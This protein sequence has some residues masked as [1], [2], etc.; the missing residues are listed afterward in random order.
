[1]KQL[2]SIIIVA[3]LAGP[4]VGPAVAADA[5]WTLGFKGGLALSDLGGDDVIDSELGN[6]TGFAGGVFAQV[7]VSQNFGIRLEGLYHMK[8]ASEDSANASAT[9]KFDYIE[10]PVLLVGQ[11]PASESATLS[12]FAGPVMAFNTSSKLAASIGDFGGSVDI[13]DYIAAFEFS[14]AFGLGAS[15]DVGSVS[16]EVDGRYQLGLTTVDDGLGQAL[17]I[18]AGDLDIKNQGWVFMAGVGFPV[19]D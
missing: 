5:Q 17:D 9:F 2:L 3:L 16:I 4:L 7:D 14:L 10:F 13:K 11:V 18:S 15:F 12:A 6:R 8:G 19:G 1:M